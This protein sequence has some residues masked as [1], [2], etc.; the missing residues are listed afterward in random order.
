M[1]VVVLDVDPK[2]PLQVASSNDEQP[3]QA[4]NA[5][6]RIQRSA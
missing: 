2:D 4:L 5:T 1:V 3:V 6:V